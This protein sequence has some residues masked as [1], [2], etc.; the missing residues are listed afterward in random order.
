MKKGRN[1][2]NLQTLYL[3]LLLISLLYISL[4][5]VYYRSLLEYRVHFLNKWLDIFRREGTNISPKR[6]SS[7]VVY[8]HLQLFRLNCGFQYY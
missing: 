2:H 6:G 4:R 7:G 8:C 3:F 5:S 1:K